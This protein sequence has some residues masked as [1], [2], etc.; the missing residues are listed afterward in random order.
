MRQLGTL[1]NDR[2]ARRF[3]AWLVSQRIEAHAEEESGG[4]VIWVRDEDQLPRAREALAHFRE[5]PQD[6]RYQNAE[7]VAEARLRE[8]EAKRRQALSNVVQMRGRWSAG[9]TRAIASSSSVPRTPTAHRRS[10]CA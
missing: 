8:E 1:P 5:H 6:P 2:E 9:A 7:Q 10:S 4:W 3:A